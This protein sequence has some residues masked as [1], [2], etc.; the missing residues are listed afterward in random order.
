MFPSSCLLTIKLFVSLCPNYLF[1]YQD[2]AG[3]FELIEVV[4]NGTYGQVYK[5]IN[6]HPHRSDVLCCGLLNGPQYLLDG[7]VG[8]LGA[9]HHKK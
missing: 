7:I 1:F 6:T 4:G 5:V 9:A 8:M 2:P 3:I